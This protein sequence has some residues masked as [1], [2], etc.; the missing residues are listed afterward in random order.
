M[1]SRIFQLEVDTSIAKTEIIDM[2]RILNEQ[3]EKLTDEIQ[4]EFAKVQ[5][6]HKLLINDTE[7]HVTALKESTTTLTNATKEELDKLTAA[8]RDIY[9]KAEDAVIG[10]DKRLKDLEATGVG[11][12]GGSGGGG[13]R[14]AGVG[15]GGG[16]GLK[17]ISLLSP[18][19]RIP[20]GTSQRSGGPGSA[21]R[22]AT[23][24]R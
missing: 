3:R 11:S 2:R 10:L 23:S 6:D 1:V 4:V 5:N 15:E 21:T 13:F 18:R 24:T 8:H 17:D 22:W 20:S 9:K 19:C 7:R 14:Q 16:G 12:G